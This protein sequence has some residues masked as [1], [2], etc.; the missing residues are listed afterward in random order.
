M[1]TDLVR[2]FV[3]ED[4]KKSDVVAEVVSLVTVLEQE[5]FRKLLQEFV[6]GIDQSMLLDVH[7]LNG[8]VQLIRNAPQGYID[9]DD[10]VKILGLL[11]T[12]LKDTH[13]QSTR[14]TY[15]LA[16]TISQVLDSMV[17]SQV[18]GL[19]REQLH[20]PLSDYLEELKQDQ[21]PYLVYQATYAY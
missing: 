11:N 2:A 20:E 1:A 12:R 17:D 6:D 4:L 16:L 19:S 15:Q 18:K 13:K 21:D 10:L 8:L 5:D 9:V 3:R 14:H 7:L